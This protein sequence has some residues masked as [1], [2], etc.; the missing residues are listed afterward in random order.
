LLS[1]GY[2]GV[3]SVT[4]GSG[5]QQQTPERI[6]ANMRQRGHVGSR[7]ERRNLPRIQWLNSLPQRKIINNA[8]QYRQ[9]LQT[10]LRRR[11]A[12]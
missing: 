2:I 1:N 7:R 12:A 5:W 4:D 9:H 11:E 10:I 3:F 8:H 6:P